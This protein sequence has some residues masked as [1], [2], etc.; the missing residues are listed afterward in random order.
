MYRLAAAG[1]DL[2]YVVI[3]EAVFDL[4]RH[5]RHFF[6][7]RWRRHAGKAVPKS[8]WRDENGASGV[9]DTSNANPE[10]LLSVLDDSPANGTH[11]L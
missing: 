3:Q 6:T 11:A 5:V 4:W 1:T 7:P 9:L 2:G 8:C 10:S